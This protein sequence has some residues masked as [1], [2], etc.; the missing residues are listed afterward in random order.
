MVSFVHK[1]Y[2]LIRTR[3]ILYLLLSL[4]I[5]GCTADPMEACMKQGLERKLPPDG[6]DRGA[7]IKA[8]ER[9]KAEVIKY[10]RRQH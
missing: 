7:Y 5:V 4:V 1:R 3:P 10:E 8:R 2:C 9:K 6:A